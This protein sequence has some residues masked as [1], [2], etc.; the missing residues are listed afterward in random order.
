MS[1]ST[2]KEIC[3]LASNRKYPSHPRFG[4]QLEKD[5]I[6][7]FGYHDSNHS[8]MYRPHK[9]GRTAAMTTRGLA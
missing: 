2:E 3:P 6:S 7:I 8:Y 4:R 1:V 5:H 9:Q